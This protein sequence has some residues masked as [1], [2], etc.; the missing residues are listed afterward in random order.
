VRMYS[1]ASIPPES[2][3]PRVIVRFAPERD[4]FISG[5]LAGGGELAET[6]AVVDVPVGKGHVVFFAI[7]PMWRQETH[8][9]FMLVMNAAM[10]F[11]HLQAGRKSMPQSKASDGDEEFF[12][13]T[14]GAHAHQDN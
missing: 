6:P 1:A 2:M 7:N 12:D 14:Q 4:L 11:D 5:E 9:M 10:N 13:P 8:G 3:W